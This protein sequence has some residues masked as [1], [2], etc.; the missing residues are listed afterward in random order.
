VAFPPLAVPPLGPVVPPVAL[1][2]VG[3]VVPPVLAF[4]PVLLAPPVP[5]PQ[6]PQV[7][8]QAPFIQDCPHQL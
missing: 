3:L 7:K 1:P 2:P 4:P 6:S 8:A 5:L